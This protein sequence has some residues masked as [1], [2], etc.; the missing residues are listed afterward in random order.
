M[1]KQAIILPFLFVLSINA[2][3]DRYYT[4]KSKTKTDVVQTVKINRSMPQPQFYAGSFYAK[5]TAVTPVFTKNGRK[6][7]HYKVSIYGERGSELDVITDEA[8][9]IGSEVV[10]IYSDEGEKIIPSDVF[11]QLFN[12]GNSK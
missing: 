9:K 12:K 11:Q 7:Q 2:N 5:V 6:V 8:P 4:S 1:L 3:A 10:Y